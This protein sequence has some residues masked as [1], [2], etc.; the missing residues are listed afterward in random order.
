MSRYFI[1]CSICSCAV[2]ALYSTD[3]NFVAHLKWH[4]H[5]NHTV[6]SYAA[7]VGDFQCSLCDATFEWYYDFCEHTCTLKGSGYLK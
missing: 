6:A 4:A 5:N 1:T 2:I 7:S 3:P